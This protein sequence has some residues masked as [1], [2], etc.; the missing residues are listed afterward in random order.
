MD[1]SLRIPCTDASGKAG[2]LW[3]RVE[4]LT[5][6]ACILRRE[7]REKEASQLLGEALP[8]LLREWSTH[9]GLEPSARKA[10]LRTLIDE[11]QRNVDAAFLQRRMIVDEL[12]QRI[13]AK[14]SQIQPKAQP[15]APSKGAI[16][17]L[18]RKVAISDVCGMID[19]INES[20]SVQECEDLLP[21]RTLLLRQ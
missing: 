8:P 13:E 3:E 16:F 4:Q 7:N 10:R 12:M 21:M 11:T 9:C 17:G 5:T 6:E 15:K 20:I 19:A 14:G 18:R 1:S 2:R